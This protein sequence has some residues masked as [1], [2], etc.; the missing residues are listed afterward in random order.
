MIGGILSAIGGAIKV[1]I[2]CLRI[3]AKGLKAAMRTGKRLSKNILRA[4]KKGKK[5][6]RG[7]MR[8][9]N[10]SRELARQARQPATQESHIFTPPDVIAKS[11]AISGKQ[12]AP[13]PTEVTQH[14]ELKKSHLFTKED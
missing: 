6:G 7:V 13:S 4:F 5:L 9:V 14:P 11:R 8:V 12:N 10:K 3:G 1:G 2:G